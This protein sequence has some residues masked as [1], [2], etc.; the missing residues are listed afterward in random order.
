MSID[1]TSLIESKSFWQHAYGAYSPNPPLMED[2]KV[3]VAIVGGGF[4]GLNTAWQFKK[5]NPNARVVV[6]EAAI[7]GFGA[8][9]RNAGFSTKMFGLEPEVVL[10]RWGKQKMID[11][12]HYL[13]LAV[14]HT[15]S[16]IEQNNF[17]SDYQHS[18]LVRASYSKQQ[19]GRMK[20]TYEMF[21][22]LGIDGDMRWRNAVEF[23]QDFHSERFAGGIYE[24]DT[25]YLNPCKQVRALKSLAE[26]ANV[27]VYELTPVTSVEATSSAVLVTTP[28]GKI[29]AEKLV[30]ATNAYSRQV[31]GPARLRSRQ[32]PLWT[33]Q[34][35]TEPLSNGQWAS[36][37][38][39][40]RQSF[41]D[42]RQMLHYFRPTAD[43]RI[44]MGGGDAITYR[45]EPMEEVSAP[46]AWQHC[47]DHLKWIYPQLKNVRVDYRW[48]GPVSV[49]MDSA[50]EISFIDGER[51][52]YSG[53]CF[54]HGVA[55]TH[56]NGRTIA[57]L[58]EGKK[59]ELTEFWIVNRKSLS[60]SSDTLSFLA[61]RAARQALKSW[62]WW[63]ERSLK[64]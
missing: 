12:H 42:N 28:H 27:S 48:G 21:Q 20:K 59:S 44:I 54:G 51:I 53:G 9:G 56:L 34:I 38:W 8:S 32:Y 24:S 37:G 6:L 13:K 47:E 2:L 45:T 52:I 5:D 10:L 46:A 31:P 33:Y 19:L 26:S 63:E 49:T 30:V 55:L 16:L 22:K 57:D 15:R 40:D 36:I 11:A 35:V 4:T 17:Q 3:D 25:G 64:K 39:K 1:Q 18:G 23:Q 29:T 50:P 62:D 14:A 60:M 58:L 61:G 7:V 43:G 41:G